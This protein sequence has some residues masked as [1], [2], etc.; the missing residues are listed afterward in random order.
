MRK[1]LLTLLVIAVPSIAYADTIRADCDALGAPP[2]TARNP[3][4]ALASHLSHARCL[5]AATMDSLKLSD[6]DQSMTMLEQA[7]KPELDTIAEVEK[8]GDPVLRM[9]AAAARADLYFTM[10]VRMRNTIPKVPPQ[11]AGLRLMQD[12]QSIGD[13]HAALEPKL[14]TWLAE[15]VGALQQVAAI[16]QKNPQLAKNPV[17]S[18]LVTDTQRDLAAM[19]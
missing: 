3:E 4:P 13:M 5:A 1:L 18:A 9:E 19:R 10:I 6:D 7:A 11:D 16:S 17:A 12:E 2:Q 8:N 14:T 15:G